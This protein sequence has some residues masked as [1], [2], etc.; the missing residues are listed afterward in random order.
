MEAVPMT[1]EMDDAPLTDEQKLQ[2]ELELVEE[3]KARVA[4][5]A[6]F[7]SLARS[8]ETRF[9]QRAARRKTKESQW[10]KATELYLGNLVR[11]PSTT[12]DQ[13]FGGA[14]A[15]SR[16]YYNIVASKCDIAIAQS[17]DMQFAGGEKNWSLGPGPNNRDPNNSERA[18]LMEKEIEAQ[19]ERCGY[20]KKTRRAIEDRVI[21]GSG[22]LKGPVNTGKLYTTYAPIPGTDT[23]MPTPSVDKTLSIE[24]VNPW[25]FFPDDSVNDFCKV[26]DT[27]E[28]HPCSAI[29]L[30]KWRHHPGFIAEALEEALKAKPEEYLIQSYTDYS[31]ITDTNPYLFKEKYMVLEYHG[32][33][34]ADELAMLSIEP[35]AYDP[36]NEEYYGEVWVCAGKVIR[37]ELENI[38]ASFE[39]PYA[40]STWKKD[41]SSV[42]GFG[43]PLLMQDSQRVARE[44]WRMVLDN[45]SLSSGPQLAMHRTY[46]EPQD[47][48]W[49][50]RPN[51]AWNLL[52]SAVD[53][54][55][56]I[57]FFNV[58][59]MTSQLLPILD[60]ARGMAEEESMM[61][62]ISAGLGG[63]D[64][65]ESASGGLMMREAATTI[66]DFLSE[67]WDD[68]VTEKLIRRSYGW[69][70]Q[71]NP[72]ADIKGEYVVDVRTATEF[73]NKQMHA[74][75]LERLSMEVSQNPQAAMLV[76]QEELYRARLAVMKIP[77]G[78]I[79]RSNEE[80]AQIRAQQ[81]EQPTP[82]SIEMA[83]RER[84]IAVEERKLA[85]QES[86]LEFERQQQQVREMMDHQERMSAN[87]ARELEAQAAVT[88]TQ[89]EK[90]TQ[91]L[92]L[93]QKMEND[94]E[95]NALLARIAITNNETKKFA[96]QL[97][98]NSK[99]RKDLLTIEEM[100]I[101]N[102]MGTGI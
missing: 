19:L 38:E 70:M 1:S 57:Q 21:I 92:Q 86:T 90:D 11:S 52:D 63:A 35:P 69:N 71:Y 84:E 17:V 68:N 37:I 93:A 3:A 7:D 83:L 9:F 41:P 8:I 23:W 101:K 54:E 98:A 31:H 43:A 102:K 48:S 72:L 26:G 81:A 5:D 97:D 6:A 20:G 28:V 12:S 88:R 22:I 15:S 87:R 62:M 36:V 73:K 2:A 16:P 74:R 33:I 85:L 77:Y 53:V 25:F 49:E 29:E 80:I 55:K 79:V 66:V 27:I 94:K 34:S 50:L 64:V 42:F 45:A 51:K 14:D 58:P 40:L 39:V 56:A 91:F 75:D 30:K 59:N 99:A 82:E 10:L 18:R 44:V 78:T 65:Q 100:K 95:R 4:R 67:D 13:P 46:V 76:N 24:W 61:P 89:N 47:G 32:P 96:L 60:V